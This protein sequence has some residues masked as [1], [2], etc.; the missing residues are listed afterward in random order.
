LL[1]PHREKGYGLGVYPFFLE[2]GGC[3]GRGGVFCNQRALKKKEEKAKQKKNA[4]KWGR[5][6]SWVGFDTPPGRKVKKPKGG[7]FKKG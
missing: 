1:V 4:T 5:Q 7:N 3:M 6:K 2:G